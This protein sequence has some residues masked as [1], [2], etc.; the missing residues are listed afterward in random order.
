[1]KKGFYLPPSP[2]EVMFLSAAHTY[3]NVIGLV[4][5]VVEALKG[6]EEA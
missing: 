6:Q 1:L 4:S 3:E 2:Y 5:A